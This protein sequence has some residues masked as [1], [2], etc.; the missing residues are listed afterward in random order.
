MTTDDDKQSP[1]PDPWAGLDIG[2]TDDKV[3]DRSFDFAGLEDGPQPDFDPVVEEPAVERGI[4][5]PFESVDPPLEE[6]LI[7]A[8]HADPDALDESVEPSV[9]GDASL[10]D[11]HHD[12]A[13]NEIPLAVFPPPEVEAAGSDILIGTG[14]SG[15]I[16]MVDVPDDLA[17]EDFGVGDDANDEFDDRDIAHELGLAGLGAEPMAGDAA[18]AGSDLG[19]SPDFGDLASDPQPED[20][21]FD[22]GVIGGAFPF[23]DNDQVEPVADAVD[24]GQN[25]ADSSGLPGAAVVAAAAAAASTKPGV[26]AASTKNSTK[27]TGS[28]IGQMV[29][30][31]LGGL[32]ALPVTYAIL[33]WGFHKDPFKFAKKTPP[34]LAFLLPEKLQPGYRPPK[35]SEPSRGLQAGP[36]LDDIPTGDDVAMAAADQPA[37]TDADEPEPTEPMDVAGSA[38][39]PASPVL[40]GEP[41]ATPGEMPEVVEQADEPVTPGVDAGADAAIAVPAMAVDSGLE[42]VP[43]GDPLPGLDGVADDADGAAPLASS[44][45]LPPLDLTGVEAAAERASQAFEALATVSDPAD[46]TRDR[47]SVVWYRRLVQLGEELVTLETAA[48]DSGRPLSEPPAAATVL[49]DRIC[50]SDAAVKDLERLGLMWLTTQKQRADGVTLLATLDTSRQV[51]PYWS[52]RAVVSG[53]RADGVDRTVAVIS[54]LAPPAEAGDRVMISGVLFDGDTVWAADVRPIDRP[55]QPDVGQE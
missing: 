25:D 38:D 55:R 34:Q 26:R 41:D 44:P 37:A 49:F 48:A 52:T 16:S 40:P 54:R 6:P 14:R 22:T 1:E 4:E 5:L 45:A 21:S 23:A 24:S 17:Q 15:I 31:V 9:V 8:M 7:A 20:V 19:A 28:G 53:G 32:M 11:G 27:K 2:G 35:K 13:P 47:L 12:A 29:G 46:P 42:G 39:E 43:G 36:S 10:D 50:G 51:G 30:V 3:E 33:I 18:D